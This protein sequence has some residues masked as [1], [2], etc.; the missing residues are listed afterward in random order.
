VRG[1]ILQSTKSAPDLQVISIDEQLYLLRKDEVIDAVFTKDSIL[2]QDD[3]DRI[4]SFSFK[5]LN[6]APSVINFELTKKE[7]FFIDRLSLQSDPLFTD[8]PQ[9]QQPRRGIPAAQG[10]AEGQVAIWNQ[11]KAQDLQGQILVATHVTVKYAEVL[12]SIA[13]LILENGSILSHI[14]ILAREQ[15]VPCIIGVKGATVI[16]RNKRIQMNGDSGIIRVL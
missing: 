14:S 7:I 3:L 9:N 13:G 12:K 6:E 15:R 2:A 5:N 4:L 11:Q 1:K 8:F 16:L 10:N